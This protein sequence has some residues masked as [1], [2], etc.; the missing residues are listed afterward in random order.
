MRTYKRKRNTIQIKW[1]PT[2]IAF[3][4]EYKYVLTSYHDKELDLREVNIAFYINGK[5]CL[6]SG[7]EP[8][9]YPINA[10][11]ELPEPYKE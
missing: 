6:N 4:E 11:A 2:S 3:P 10:W 8:Q 9:D 7:Y 5:W 1:I